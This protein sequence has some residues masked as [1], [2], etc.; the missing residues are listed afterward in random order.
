[1]KRRLLAPFTWLLT[2]AALLA[3]PALAGTTEVV[4]DDFED[5]DVVGWII[6]ADLHNGIIEAVELDGENVGKVTFGS[7]CYGNTF[8]STNLQ[9][10]TPFSGACV[11]IVTRHIRA[12]QG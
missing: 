12:V 4:M 6:T 8:G 3:A 10:L 7:S 1:M 9:V 11:P 5:G 2:L